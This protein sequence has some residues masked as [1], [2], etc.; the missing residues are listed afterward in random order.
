MLIVILLAVSLSR[1]SKLMCSNKKCQSLIMSISTNTSLN[2]TSKLGAITWYNMFYLFYIPW[3]WF[4]YY[5]CYTKY[6]C[7]H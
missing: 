3:L 7:V 6:I 4:S 2:V 1:Q 5:F